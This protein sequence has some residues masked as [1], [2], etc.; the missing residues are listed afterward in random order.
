MVV[1]ASTEPKKHGV[2]G[3]ARLA[4]LRFTMSRHFGD[5]VESELPQIAIFQQ[6]T[7][8]QQTLVTDA[9]AV[10]PT[11]G[12]GDSTVADAG[13][14][15]KRPSDESQAAAAP[16]KEVTTK[17]ATTEPQQQQKPAAA[18]PSIAELLAAQAAELA[19]TNAKLKGPS[20]AKRVRTDH[21][22]SP[23]AVSLKVCITLTLMTP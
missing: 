10:P 2:R 9:A 19:R 8:Q 12:T 22:A 18:T 15:R 21:G 5:L 1:F 17:A 6:T 14:K 3:V 7:V 13:V 11:A 16:P 23:S 4:W 20:D